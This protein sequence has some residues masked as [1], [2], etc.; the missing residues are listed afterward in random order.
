MIMNFKHRGLQSLFFEGNSAKVRQSHL[1]RL[2][3]I[4]AKLNASKHISD[5]NFPGSDLHQL[6]GDKKGFWAISVSANWRLI[7]RFENENVYDLDYLD[8]H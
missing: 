6:K 4:L 7:F 1:K 5:M 8:Y 2:R 3:L